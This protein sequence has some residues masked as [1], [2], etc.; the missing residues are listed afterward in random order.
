MDNTKRKLI[1]TICLVIGLLSFLS[2]IA[3]TAVSYS[4]NAQFCLNCHSMDE[5]YASL[6]HSNHKQ[7]K[8]T[9]CHAPHS[10]LPKVVFK[11][12]SGLRD[13]YA[14][15]LGEVPQVIRATGESKEI[16]TNNCIRCHRTTVEQT[17]MGQGRLCMDCHRNLVHDR[18]SI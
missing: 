12:K 18:N 17:G 13:L 14:T 4:D 2:I 3:N 5:A 16:I 10:Y 6:Q 15:T 11:T 9:E 8:C 1:L 7:F